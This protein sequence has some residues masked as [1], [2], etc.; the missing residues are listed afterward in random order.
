MSSKT[1]PNRVRKQAGR[2]SGPLL[3]VIAMFVACLCV[4]GAIATGVVRG[5]VDQRTTS[6]TGFEAVAISAYIQLNQNL[7]HD[8]NGPNQQFV[9][10]VPEG[11]SAASVAQDLATQGI[12]PDERLLRLYMRQQGLD[13]LIEA[14]EF[15]LNTNMSVAEIAV[16]LTDAKSTDFDLRIW[17]GW[18]VEQIAESMQVAGHV[19]FNPDAF[20]Q[21][22]RNVER[23][24]QQYAF[25]E[26]IPAD[27][28]LEGFLFP[29]TYNILRDT[30]SLGVIDSALANFDQQYSAEMR[31]QTAERNLTIYQ[32]VTIA[33]IVEREA[34][35]PEEQP[36]IAEV[37]LNRLA[38]GMRLQADPTTQYGIASATNWWPPLNVSPAN[39][40]HGYNTY[41]IDGLPP[42]PISNPS[43][44]AMQAVL[45]PTGYGYIFFQAQC[46]GSGYHNFAYTYEEH[47]ANSC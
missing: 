36:I 1:Q 2:R 43:L 39:I 13:S 6:L 21:Q 30:S 35:H 4:G 24:K 47:L 33:S 38:Q 18:R 3:A 7:L 23:V 46:D 27:A 20:Q 17:E 34:V 10:N 37:Y 16:A 22:V 8:S 29:D 5:M 31:A 14:G 40:N 28:T 19:D 41:V 12:I 11:A 32:V 25:A 9:Y 45:N 15:D 26:S 42:G 44:T